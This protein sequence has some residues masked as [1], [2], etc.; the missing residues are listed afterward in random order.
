MLE[1][2]NWKLEVRNWLRHCESSIIII[3]QAK[4]T[5]SYSIIPSLVAAC[6]EAIQI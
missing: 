6:D 3:K 2:R 1:V 4:M 5:E